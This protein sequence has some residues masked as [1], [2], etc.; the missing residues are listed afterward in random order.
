MDR[1]EFDKEKL[2]IWADEGI[3]FDVMKKFSVCYDSFAN[4]IVFPIK[5]FSGDIINVSGRTLDRSFKE[6][7][8][9]K[10]TYYKPLGALDT[11]YGFSD[12]EPFISEKKE[13]VIFEGAK[14]V[15]LASTW[16]VQNCCAALTSHLNPRQA[17][18]LIRLGVRVVFAFDE[19]VDITKDKNIAKL[20]RYVRVEWVK[21]RGGLLSSKMAPVDAGAAVWNKLYGMRQKLN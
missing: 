8:L 13:I 20:M 12:N 3:G 5:S 9:R 1:Y 10:Y 4:R 18:F 6:K 14:S 21:N 7:G 11:L 16:G 2:Q 19:D 17:L 15:M